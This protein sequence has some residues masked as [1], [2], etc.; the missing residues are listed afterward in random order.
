[1]LVS[2]FFDKTLKVWYLE[3]NKCTKTI[4]AHTEE[5]WCVEKASHNQILSGSKD[6]TIKLW[7]LDE[8]VF[9]RSFLGH[10]RTVIWLI[11]LK[12]NTSQVDPRKK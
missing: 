6:A 3:T 1:M 12:E 7:D 9:L 2:S 11:M 10:S 8:V 5:I 4:N